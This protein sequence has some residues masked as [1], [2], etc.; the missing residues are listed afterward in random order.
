GCV[1][2][3]NYERPPVNLPEA[4]RGQAEQPTA[5]SIA[6]VKW[7]ELFQDEQLQALI[8]A[9]LDGNYDVR[10]AAARILEAEAQLGITHA[11]ELPSV[12]A[13]ASVLGQKPPAALFGNASRSVLAVALQGAASW[14]LDFWG[15]YR[16]A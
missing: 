8:S 12:T 5:G 3:R 16:R 4:F 6:D 10:I 2:G 13:G 14:Q 9:A 15:R 1:T 7:W 11:D